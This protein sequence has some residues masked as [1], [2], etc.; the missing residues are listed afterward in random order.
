ML[1]S[2]NYITR[3]RPH[4]L[5]GNGSNTL[6]TAKS[7]KIGSKTMQEGIFRRIH[8]IQFLTLAMFFP[9]QRNRTVRQIAYAVLPHYTDNT[10][11]GNT[12]PVSSPFNSEKISINKKQN[13]SLIARLKSNPQNHRR[14]SK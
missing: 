8:Q 13:P 1:F 7:R 9:S 3:K 6:S 11:Q 12:S 5:T 14:C 4:L 10:M 2:R